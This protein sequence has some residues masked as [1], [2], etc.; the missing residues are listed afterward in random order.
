MSSLEFE[1][2][3][4]WHSINL[5]YILNEYNAFKSYIENMIEMIDSETEDK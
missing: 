2:L 5:L 4:G 1:N 3:V